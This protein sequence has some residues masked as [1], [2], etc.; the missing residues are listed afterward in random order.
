[1][2]IEALYAGSVR[3]LEPSGDRTGIFKK[4]IEQASIGELGIAGDVQVDKRYHGGADKALHQFALSSYQKIIEQ[5][6]DLQ[7]KAVPGSI[8][9]NLSIKD[10]DEHNVCI[11]D[12]YQ[13]GKVIIQVS[14]P[15][16]PCWKINAKYGVGELSEYIER[17]R[18]AGWYYR[19]LKGGD[20]SLGEQ[21]S[22]LERL[23]GSITIDYFNRVKNQHR[24][25][26]SGLE[27][28]IN[29]KGLATG[30]KEK[31]QARLDY[32]MSHEC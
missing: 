32:L 1:M 29:A 27:S 15:R 2:K 26:Q 21:V 8:G 31:L 19:V 6:P 28:L 17:Q 4:P 23:N 10:M 24:P 3:T 9:E 25:S 20:V 13:L 18:I 5:Y 14:E 11:G 16:Q 30:L 12:V 7:G 22:L